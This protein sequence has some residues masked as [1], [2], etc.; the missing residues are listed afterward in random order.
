MEMKPARALPL[1]D[2]RVLLRL[3]G[4]ARENDKKS[5]NSQFN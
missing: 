1:E 3:S 2:Y 4:E 5:A